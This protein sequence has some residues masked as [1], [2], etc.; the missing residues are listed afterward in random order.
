MELPSWLIIPA[1]GPVYRAPA[2]VTE[3]L[4]RVV[5][6]GSVLDVL[7]GREL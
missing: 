7:I 4:V 1:L 6:G 3:P 5:A 2:P